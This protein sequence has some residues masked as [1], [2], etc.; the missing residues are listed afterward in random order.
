MDLR[1]ELQSFGSALHGG[2]Y[3]AISSFGTF[4]AW[5]AEQTQFLQI[6]HTISYEMVDGVQAWGAPTSEALDRLMSWASWQGWPIDVSE[7]DQMQASIWDILGGGRGQVD[8]A[9]VSVTQHAVLLHSETR[10]DLLATVPIQ[11]PEPVPLLI[12]GLVMVAINRR[13][14]S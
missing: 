3:S 12:L 8:T 5:C 1:I 10:Q 14:W 4:P 11:E 6:G 2:Q 9:G 7:N 13:V